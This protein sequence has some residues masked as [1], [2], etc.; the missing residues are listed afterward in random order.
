[1]VHG[2]GAILGDAFGKAV[3]VLLTVEPREYREAIGLAIGNLPDVDMM[4]FDPEYL[5]S[6]VACL[7][8]ELAICRALRRRRIRRPG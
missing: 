2:Q 1:M 6:E 3:R 5:I 4:V 7:A 8:Q